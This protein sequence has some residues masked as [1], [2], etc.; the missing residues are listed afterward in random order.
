[1]KIIIVGCGKVGDSLAEQLS[2][3]NYDITVIDKNPE[4]IAQVTN[5]F[6]VLGLVGDGVSNSCL[7][8]AGVADTDLLI[9]VTGSDEKNLLCCLI[10]KKAGHCATIARVRNPEY[11]RE[12][13]FLKKEFGLAMVINP[14]MIAAVEMARIFRFPSAIKIDALAKGYLEML[15]FRI[16]EKCSLCGKQVSFVRSYLSPDVLVCMIKRKGTILVPTGES[17][18]EDGDIVTIVAAPKSAGT[19]FKKIG[20][21]INRVKNA[22]IVG[23]GKISFYLAKLLLQSGIEVK[24]IEQSKERCEE[25]SD[26]LPQASL[27]CGDA[28]DQT[29]FL[30]EGLSG[31][32]GAAILTN[33]DEENVFLSL[34]AKKHS[35]AKII[36]KVNRMI[37][38]EVIDD[39]DLDSLV[40]PKLL[41]ADYIL[42]YVR[43][44]NASIGSSM[45]SLYTLEDSKENRAEALQYL[46]TAK[47]AVVGVPLNELKTKKDVL[48]CCIFRKGKMMIPGGQDSIEIGDTVIVVHNNQHINAITDILEER[49]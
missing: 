27:I 19:F 11:S 2:A 39:L 24:I 13:D 20:L 23:G 36:T 21:P 25:L 31:V 26:R 46:I 43:T 29:I 33:I 41:T 22:L 12:A 37:F 48:I 5:D 40:Y 44:M 4:R 10:A 35:H 3:E 49:R 28:T 14:E 1:M 7:L 15:H 38:N 6:D 18:F 30:E 8:E 45:E 47:S 9:A 34:F 17:S 16:T 32:D 42:Q